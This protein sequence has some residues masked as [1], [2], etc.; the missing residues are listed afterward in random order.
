LAVL[1]EPAAWMRVVEEVISGLQGGVGEVLILVV[2]SHFDLNAE[3]GLAAVSF[4][5]AETGTRPVRSWRRGKLG[6]ARDS[7]PAY[8][9][10]CCARVRCTRAREFAGWQ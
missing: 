8:D 1:V 9:L 2:G 5:A 3:A 6:F 10:R 4:N 7:P